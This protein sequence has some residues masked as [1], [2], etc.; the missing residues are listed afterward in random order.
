MR[1]DTVHT[2]VYTIYN[3]TYNFTSDTISN[4]LSWHQYR[5]LIDD[6]LEQGLVTGPNQ[7]DSLVAYTRMNVARMRRLEKTVHLSS[8][9]ESAVKSVKSPLI[10]IAL[11]EGWCGD[12][13]QILPVVEKMAAQNEDISFRLILRDQHPEIMDAFLTNRARSIPKIIFLDA[14]DFSEVYVWGPRPRPAAELLISLKEQGLAAANIA[15]ELHRWYAKD[16]SMTLMKEF[17]E[18]FLNICSNQ[19]L[20]NTHGKE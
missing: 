2:D 20:H 17:E 10:L 18:I 14:H 6:L 16:K 3:M 4:S 13:A 19:V 11:T 15:E 5:L 8:T 1:H 9:L 7:G 12:A